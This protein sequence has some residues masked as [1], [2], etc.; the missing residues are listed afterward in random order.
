MFKGNVD[1]IRL[2]MAPVL[3]IKNLAHSQK[4]FKHKKTISLI[5]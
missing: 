5:L 1:A 4:F 3:Y 2:T